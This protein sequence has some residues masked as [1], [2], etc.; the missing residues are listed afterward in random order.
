MGFGKPLERILFG[1]RQ[2]MSTDKLPKEG[3]ILRGQG[4]ALTAVRCEPNHDPKERPWIFQCKPGLP[5]DPQ[6]FNFS[7]VK[8]KLLETTTKH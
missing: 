1:K 3:R 2:G 8:W 6:K 4:Q 7:W 5:S